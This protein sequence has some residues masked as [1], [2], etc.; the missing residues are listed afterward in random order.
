MQIVHGLGGIKL[1]D[2]YSLI[3]N[4]SKKK[5]DK[6]DKERP[7]FVEGSQKQGLSKQA[8]DEL[9]ELILKFAGYGFNKSHSTG[10]AIVAYQ[11]AYLK[12]YFPNQYMAAF[13]TFESGA[14]KVSDWIQYVEDC[15][16]VRFTNGKVGVEVR[17]PDVN[18]SQADFSVV[19]GPGEAREAVNGHVRFGIG[20]IKGVGEK[21]IAAIIEERDR[22]T[23]GSRDQGEEESTHVPVSGA[24]PL[25]PR[26]LDA[27]I[28]FSSLHDFCDRVLSRSPSSTGSGGSG[29]AILNKGTVEALVK[30]GAMDALHGRENRAAMI[31]SIEPAMSAAQKTAADKAAGQGGLFLGGPPPTATPTPKKSEPA[32]TGGL[33]RVAPWT[34]AETLQS[35]KESLG[36]YV[37]SHPLTRWKQWA[38]VFATATCETARAGNQDQRVV[39]PGLVQGIRTIVVK[40]GRSA[41]QKMAI[42]TLEDELGT[43]EAVLFADCFTQFAHLLTQD[44]VVFL[45]GRVDRSRAGML[46]QRKKG[47]GDDEEGAS[48][49]GAGAP[50]GNENVQIVVDR[51]VPI[52]G[53]PLMPGR[54]WLRVDC[55]KLNGSGE[56]VLRSVAELVKGGG[57]VV[58]GFASATPGARDRTSVVEPKGGGA[59]PPRHPTNPD[60]SQT[61]PV[62]IVLD[63]AE[64]RVRL[65]VPPTLRVL[66]S[67]MFIAALSERLGE[68]SVRVVGGVAVEL[69]GARPRWNGKK[70]G[71]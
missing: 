28:P 9:F 8:A 20:A 31:A 50:S 57:A 37:S 40:N 60:K 55:E 27:S 4:I 64:A 5:H 46:A 38:G 59:A 6:I 7:K 43:V 15:K 69:P 1:R 67:P 26:S 51:V 30:C 24:S 23:K 21:A 39:L 35:E 13:L 53:V 19:Y 56:Q 25:M 48:V 34:E 54:M 14:Q 66:P 3:K 32:T 29:G 33:I 61:F 45:L 68:G 2:A 11:T 58:D 17:P 70:R 52:D 10:Y 44:A 71:D 49:A 65:E 62:E 47:G 63:T 16:K 41:G 22:G 42:V 12:T 18:L 36:F